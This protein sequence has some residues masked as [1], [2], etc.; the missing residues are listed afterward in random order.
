[1][2]LGLA[3]WLSSANRML[4]NMK[5]SKLVKHIC[6][7][8]TF[9]DLCHYHEKNLPQLVCWPFQRAIDSQSKVQARLANLS[10]RIIVSFKLLSVW[11]VCC[12]A[13]LYL[14]NKGEQIWFSERIWCG[15]ENSILRLSQK[16]VYLNYGSTCYLR[17]NKLWKPS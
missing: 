17:I 16:Y 5:W 9:L 10:M 15:V 1:M 12:T 13:F 7:F 11:V 4:L 3:M 2:A 8:L 6:D 14:P